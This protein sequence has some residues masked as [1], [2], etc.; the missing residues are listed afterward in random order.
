MKQGVTN[1]SL[2][3]LYAIDNWLYQTL[4]LFFASIIFFCNGVTCISL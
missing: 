3:L 4:N 1:D 2:F